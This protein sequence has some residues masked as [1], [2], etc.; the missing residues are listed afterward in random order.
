MRHCWASATYVYT[1]LQVCHP[2]REYAL[3]KINVSVMPGSDSMPGH[4]AN[5]MWT[6][7]ALQVSIHSQSSQNLCPSKTNLSRC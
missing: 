6:R 3:V 1:R 7:A 2:S 5:V 4:Y